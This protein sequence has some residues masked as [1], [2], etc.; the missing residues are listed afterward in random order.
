LFAAMNHF[1]LAVALNLL[2]QSGSR[3]GQGDHHQGQYD[4]E[5]DQN[6]ARLGASAPARWVASPAH[7]GG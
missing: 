3:R 4:Q 6:V 1:D 2:R 7:W 5:D